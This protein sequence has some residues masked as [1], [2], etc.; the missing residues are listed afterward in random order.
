[1]REVGIFI[2]ATDW[3]GIKDKYRIHSI[4]EREDEEQAKVI[5][6]NSVGD[7]ETTLAPKS[8]LKKVLK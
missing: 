1:M 5:F 4:V 7:L 3:N 2:T 8:V 6:Y